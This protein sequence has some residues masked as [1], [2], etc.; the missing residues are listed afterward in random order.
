VGAIA[1]ARLVELGLA[2]GSANVHPGQGTANRRFF[3][4]NGMVELLWVNDPEAAQSDQIRQTHLWER[5][6]NRADGVCP[7]G[8]CLRPTDRSADQI[9]FPHWDFRP[10]YLPDT[11]SIA[12]GTN[13]AVLTEPMVFQMPFGK[14]PDQFPTEKAQPLAHPADVR[15]ITRVTVISPALDRPS[16]AWQAVLET[17]QV[18]LVFG[19]E[20]CIELGFDGEGQGQRLDCRW[21]PT[22]R[23]AS[24]SENRRSSVLPLVLCW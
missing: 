17:G 19:A 20:F 18:Q 6:I 7:F 23:T 1:A 24:R 3:F 4:H 10:P 12:V 5:W 16:E 9:A 22:V 15:E 13:S 11:L 14:R 2:E 21:S 8:I